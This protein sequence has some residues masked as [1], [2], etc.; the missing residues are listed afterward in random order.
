MISTRLKLTT[1][2][3]RVGRLIVALSIGLCACGSS[4]SEQLWFSSTPGTSATANS[5]YA[6][7]VSVSA[8]TTSVTFILEESPSGMSVSP[9]GLVSWQPTDADVGEHDVE[10]R[11]QKGSKSGVQRWTVTVAAEG[12]ANSFSGTPRRDV[13]SAAPDPIARTAEARRQG[14]HRPTPRGRDS[15]LEDG[16]SRSARVGSPLTPLLDSAPLRRLEPSILVVH[17]WPEV[18][19]A[20]AAIGFRCSATSP[21][22]HDRPKLTVG[23]PWM[24]VGASDDVAAAI[25]ELVLRFRPR[26]LVLSG[27]LSA[28]LLDE[29]EIR[30]SHAAS[31]PILN[32][33][34]VGRR[35][36]GQLALGEEHQ[37]VGA[38]VL[39]GG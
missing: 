1:T 23:T 15:R 32:T 37:V 2:P 18:S 20:P 26:Q 36:I 35:H 16:D 8:P 9:A 31:L 17:V 25:E 29:L 34:V 11:A 33:D 3:A 30:P 7:Q 4:L 24:Q 38:V 6:Y 22:V 10:L 14:L 21:G 28:H 12:S 19:G 39:P 27:D 13:A 5:T